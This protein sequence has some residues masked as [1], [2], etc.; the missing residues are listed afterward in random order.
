LNRTT[1]PFTKNKNLVGLLLLGGIV[2]LLFVIFRPLSRTQNNE[3]N[4]E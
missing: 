1:S 4:S 3:K 2:V